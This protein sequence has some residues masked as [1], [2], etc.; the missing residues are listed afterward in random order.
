MNI[1]TSDSLDHQNLRA[2]YS[3]GAWTPLDVAAEALRRIKAYDPSVWISLLPEDQVMQAAARVTA[4]LTQGERGP[5]MG[6]LFAVKDNIDVADQLTTAACPQ[7]AYRAT[8]TNTVVETILNAGAILVGKTNMDQFATGLVGTRSPYGTPKNPFDERYIPGGS[9]SGSAVAVAA[10]LVSFALGTDTAG[11]GRIPAAFNN[12][13]GLKP[14][15]GRL[16]MSRV[17]PAC[18]SLDCLS[19]FALMCADAA[20]VFK[21]ANRFDPTDPYSRRLHE[22]PQR[23]S[24]FPTSFRFGIPPKVQRLHHSGETDKYLD[25]AIGNLEAMGGT[26]TEID[27][28]PFA[29]AGAMLYQ[30]PWLAERLSS[31]GQFV[32]QRPEALLPVIRQ[33][34]SGASRIDSSSVFAGMTELKRLCRAAEEQWARMDVLLVPTAPTTF[35]RAQVEAEPIELNHRLGYYTNF[36]NL[37]DLCAIAIPTGFGDQHLPIGMTLI[38]PA[39]NDAA[40]I[41]LGDRLHRHSARTMGA[42][43]TALA[44]TSEI[45]CTICDVVKL[46]VVGA[47]LSGQPLNY[48]LLN[49]G[50]RLVRTCRTSPRYSLYALAGTVPPKPGLIRAGTDRGTAIEVEVWELPTA[51]F[52]QFVAAIPPPWGIGTLEMED[53]E[54]VKGFLCESYAIEGAKDITPFGGWRAFLKNSVG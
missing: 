1:T 27:F 48:Q 8:S 21:I 50:A 19:I 42:T 24:Q 6:T 31:I 45:T 46:A 11:S 47:H 54:L 16:S 12:V 5:L 41:S 40:L 7:F 38:A 17:V 25:L 10:G 52:G 49:L 2:H 36:V 33:V 14:T 51:A 35:T 9:S 26:L 22:I 44:P 30:G 3:M 29:A 43:G 34:F 15:R 28:E 18:Q 39:G 53:D 32:A 20:D 4:R 23:L 13:V 37:M